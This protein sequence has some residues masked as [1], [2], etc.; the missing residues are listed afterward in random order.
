MLSQEWYVWTVKVGKFDIVKS[1]I[2][3][4]IP[5]ISRVLYPTLTTEKR[6]KKGDIQ[7]KKSPLYAGYMFLQYNHD[8]EKPTTWL[9][10]NGHPFV[11]GYVGPCS[12]KD[13]ASVDSLQKV[14][15]LENEK[16]KSFQ[17][18][19]KIRVSGGVFAGY[20]GSVNCLTS[21]SVGVQL[22]KMGKTLKVVFSP[23]DLAIVKREPDTKKG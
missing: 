3:E 9:M 14:E 13:L 10:L 20:E 5:S 12:A 11:T 15:K 19:D 7:K 23:E 8:K 4:K 2:K 1:Y 6:T 17:L 16:V 21:N 22:S 18:G